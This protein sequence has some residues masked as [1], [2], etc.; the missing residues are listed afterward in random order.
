[1]TVLQAFGLLVVGTVAG[2]DL[3]SGPQIL[4]ARPIVAGTLTGM[5]LGDATTG[6]LVGGIL[7]LFALEVLPVGATR[8]PDH[9]PGSVAAVWL[10]VVGGP[11]TAGVAVLVALVI[12]ECGGWSLQRL[13][14]LNARALTAVAPALDRGE[15]GVASQLQFGGALRDGA[16]SLLVT[17][18]GLAL[19][20][21]ALPLTAFPPAT[22]RLV[23]VVVLGAGLAGAVAGAIRTAGE[24]RRGI[25]LAAALVFG[26]VA[27]G[28]VGIYPR[29]GL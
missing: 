12:A 14:R 6:L 24:T 13:R 26:W 28:L 4:F 9:G 18:F 17:A 25:L 7:E 10:A 8:Y 27:A 20:R 23:T 29:S 1:M 21:V 2:F 11:A 15:P 22:L 19:A 5:L 16:R 3:V